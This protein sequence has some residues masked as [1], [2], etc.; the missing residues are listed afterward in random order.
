LVAKSDENMTQEVMR[1]ELSTAVAVYQQFD[2]LAKTP[3]EPGI[4]SKMKVAMIG[5]HIYQTKI[6][7]A[8]KDSTNPNSMVR[9]REELLPFISRMNLEYTKSAVWANSVA[10]VRNEKP[11][12]M[13]ELYNFFM[14]VIKSYNPMKEAANL[15]ALKDT[16]DF[17]R[18]GQ[19]KELTTWF[20]KLWLD[21]CFKMMEKPQDLPS[22]L[23]RTDL[24]LPN[25]LKVKTAS[26]GRKWI[27]LD[28]VYRDKTAWWNR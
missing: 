2:A 5:W 9:T 19:I 26:K 12:D 13:N 6:G 4:L 20:G 22:Y 15:V 23:Q 21:K 3:N 28:K 8:G 14:T 7:M 24:D 25:F 27:D 18:R 16:D 17:D 10:N 11:M 1:K